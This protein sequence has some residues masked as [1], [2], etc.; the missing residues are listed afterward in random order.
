MRAGA[1]GPARGSSGESQLVADLTALIEK[2]LVVPVR[3][4]AAIRYAAFDEGTGV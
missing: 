2:G 4:G 1:F 3:D